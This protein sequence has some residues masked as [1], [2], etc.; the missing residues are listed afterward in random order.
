MIMETIN[1]FM[2]SKAFIDKSQ[3]LADIASLVNI[4]FKIQSITESHNL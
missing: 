1:W 2:W 3:I 4:I